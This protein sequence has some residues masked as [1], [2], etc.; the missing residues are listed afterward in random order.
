MTKTKQRILDTAVQLFNEQGTD[1]VST[2]HI[3]EAL[4]M[5]PGNLY[6]HFSN[7]EEIIRAIFERLFVVWDE[8]F[9]LPEDRL[10]TLAD[11]VGL[12]ESNFKILYEYRFIYRE[13]LALLKA[14]E[15]LHQQYIAVRERG[16]TGFREI[17]ALFGQTNI[18]TVPDE[19]TVTALADMCWM[20]SEF[21]L[22]T[23]EITGQSV[24]PEQMKRGTELMMSVLRP[25]IS[26]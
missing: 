20:I 11:A 1:V 21:W 5:S 10:P 6:Y 8:T 18:I 23:V 12:V 4:G 25:Y 3:A 19:D 26:K 17:I 15:A 7:K 2:N 9:A 14:D 13:I 16:Y 24:S 22:T